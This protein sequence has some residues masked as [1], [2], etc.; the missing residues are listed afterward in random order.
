M[1]IFRLHFRL[2]PCEGAELLNTRRGR[3]IRRTG[4]SGVASDGYATDRLLGD[5]RDPFD[6]P[7]YEAAV[8]LFDQRRTELNASDERCRQ[9]GCIASSTAHHN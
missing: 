6:T 8:R 4:P 3:P 5:F 9:L 2:G 7:L 1:C